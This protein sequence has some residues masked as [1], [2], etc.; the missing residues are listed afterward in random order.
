MTA[1]TR[2]DHV[3]NRKLRWG[4]LG[5]GFIARQ[6]AADIPSSLTGE[7]V[8]V[9]S[10]D[11]EK[12]RRF[13]E[14][15][16]IPTSY[17][18]YQELVDDEG[19]DA[20]YISLPNDLH[21]E[22]TEKCAERHKHVLC[23]KPMTMNRDEAERAVECVRRNGIVLLEAFMY[24]MHPQ[25]EALARLVREG[26][27]GEL[28]LIEASF[29][30]NMHGGHDNIR[31]KAAQGGG[32]LMDLG[33]YGVSLA[34]LVAGV[35]QGREFAD[36]VS[37][38]VAAHVGEESKVDEWASAVLT[39]EGDLI[40]TVLCGNQVDLPSEVRLWGNGGDIR[41]PNPWEAGK[42][43]EPGRILVNRPGAEPSELV[44]PSD[45]PLYAL[46]VD[47]FAECVR[48][49]RVPFPIMTLEDT[50][51]NMSTLDALRREAGVRFPVDR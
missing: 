12:G 25:M 28:R 5:T 3:E 44:L 24:R 42:R 47:G 22:W 14:E 45:L 48:T 27:V 19:V 11:E 8:A 31:M 29:G 4:I 40:A 21:L 7:V 36:P 26:A 13:A 6:F 1:Q 20:V 39:F 15:F 10:R 33:C 50:L 23:E 35:G 9:A 51:G 41:L 49:G 30:G 34:R 2:K 18:S 43:G 16:G 37:V 38:R 32:A 46:E 17:G